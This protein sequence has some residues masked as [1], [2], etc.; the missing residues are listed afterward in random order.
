VGIRYQPS[1]GAALC[2][3]AE[4]DMDDDMTPFAEHGMYLPNANPS[5]YAVGS[6]G[7]ASLLRAS[8]LEY[9]PPKRAVN[10]TPAKPSVL[11]VEA[12]DADELAE[13]VPEWKLEYVQLHPGAFRGS[14]IAINLRGLLICRGA[15]NQPLLMKVAPPPGCITIGRPARPSN[16]LLFHGHEIQAGECM[17]AGSGGSGELVS[18][19][20]LFPTTLSMRADVW[21]SGWLDESTLLSMK[22][23]KLQAP[24]PAWI[25]SYLDAIEWILDALERYPEAF[26]RVEL[27]NSLADSLL[28]RVN[29]FSSADS[30]IAQDRDMRASRRL[31]VDRAQEYISANLTEPMRLSDLCKHSRAQARSLEYGFQ[32]VMGLSPMAYVKTVRLHRVRRLLRSSTVRTRSVSEIALDGGFWHLSQFALDYKHLF[33]ES[34]SVTSRRTLAQLPR[35][36][37]RRPSASGAVRPQPQALAC[38]SD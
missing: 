7:D 28:A 25:S 32:E 31:A 27:R 17:V 35:D 5:R 2:L 36:E 14:L 1:A 3:W 18:R 24:G 10:R 33:G 26:E 22:G 37:R 29:A 38:C 4:S 20:A 34:P 16:A 23:I 13:R 11:R 19:G 8:K 30:R 12:V 6:A 9:G 21:E 15:F